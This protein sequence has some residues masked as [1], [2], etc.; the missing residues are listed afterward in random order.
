[1]MLIVDD[2]HVELVF[3]Y[4]LYLCFQFLLTVFALH[5]KVFSAGFVKLPSGLDGI[6]S[7]NLDNGCF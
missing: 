2:I 5:F 3:M 4:L 6:S 7:C 1:M